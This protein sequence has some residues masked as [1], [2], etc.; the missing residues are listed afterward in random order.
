MSF[1]GKEVQTGLLRQPRNIPL[2]NSTNWAEMLATQWLT[3]SDAL[4]VLLLLGPDIVQ[5]AVAEQA[6]RSITPVA[7]SFGWVAYAT[8]ALLSAFG[9]RSLPLCGFSRRLNNFRW[10]AHAKF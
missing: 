6:G 9:G 7:F 4:S 5:R 8:G 2:N 1:L 10:T 3:P